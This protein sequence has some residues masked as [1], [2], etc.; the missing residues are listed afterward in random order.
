MKDRL[1]VLIFGG[2]GT[3]G[4]RL[5]GLLAEE[6]RLTI[7]VAGRSLHQAEAFCAALSAR[8]TLTPAAFDREG[9]VDAQ[10]GTSHCRGRERPVRATP[11][12][13]RSCAR[14]LRGIDYLDLADGSDFV[15][16]D[17][18]ARGRGVGVPLVGLIVSDRGWLVSAKC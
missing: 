13:T 7:I 6:E 5:A 4:G 8:A 2:Y 17:V 18:Q 15:K 12:L 11:I 14:R 1:T 16:G 9:D 10:L 3:F